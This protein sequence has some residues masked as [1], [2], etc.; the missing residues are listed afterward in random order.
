MLLE[1]WLP[2]R[3]QFL[4]ELLRLE[5][6]KKGMTRSSCGECKVGAIY[7]CK[8]CFGGEVTCKECI[9]QDHESHPLHSLEKWT[10]S[11]FEPTTLTSLGHVVQ[12]GHKLSTS[13]SNPSKPIDQTV[14]DLNG[15]HRIV[16]RF[17]HCSSSS[18]SHQ[19]QL[20][21]ARW[22]P[23][24]VFRPSTS[25]S[26]NL[27]DF[28]HKLQDQNKCNSYD[29]YHTIMQRSNNAK[30]EPEIFRYNE[31][32]LVFR[33]WSHLKLLK[34]G[35]AGHCCGGVDSMSDGSLAV[36]CPA[37]PQPGKNIVLDSK[38]P[39]HF[40]TT[41]L[42]IDGCFKTKLKDRGITDPDLGTGLAY[43]VNSADYA[44]HL[45]DPAGTVSEET[46]TSCGSDL[47]AVDQAY[48]RNPKGYSVTGVVAVSCRH[49]FVRP[50]GV[51]DLQKGERY[52]NVD[53]AFAS[54]VSHELEMGVPHLVVTYDIACQWGRH[55]RER[56]ARYKATKDV[57]LD[58]LQSFRVAVPKFHLIGHGNSC[59][60]DYN[61]AFMRGVGM[62]HGEGVETIWSHSTSLATWS[63]ENGPQ[64]R[65]AL[66]DTHWSGWNW[67][68][69]INLRRL[70]KKSLE[71]AW[72]LCKVQNGIAA[73]VTAALDPALIHSWTEMM[74]AYY[75][76]SSN[77]NPF[78]EVAPSVTLNDLKAELGRVD[79][80]VKKSGT[81]HAHET[82][83]SQFIM[84][85]L[86]IEEQQSTHPGL[87]R[88]LRSKRLDPNDNTTICDQ[89]RLLSQA[90]KSLTS[91]QRV[92]M[93]GASARLDEIDPTTIT[94][95]PKTVK[96][97]LPSQLP[98]AS[99]DTSCIGNLPRLELRFRLAQAYDALD[100]IR[101]LRGVY[102]VLLVKNQAHVSTSQGTMTRTKALFRNFAL[103]I[104][105]A[106]ARYRDA[107]TA[108]LRLDPE[109]KFSPW[110]NDLKDLC[111]E[112]IRGPSRETTDTSESRRELSWIWHTGSLQPDTGINDPQ[113]QGVMRVEWCKAVARA[114]RFQEE[115]ELLVE[116]MRRTLCFFDWNAGNWEKLGE[117]RVGE[118]TIDEEITVGMRAY[119]A[120]Q[121]A[122]YR[123][124]VH[125]FIADWYECLEL[126]SLGSHWLAKYP[127]PEAAR[128]RRRRLKSN[129]KMY[130]SSVF[131][132]SAGTEDI[133]ETEDALTDDP[134][135]D[136]DPD[137]VD[138]E[139]DVDVAL[140]DLDAPLW[141]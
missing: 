75:L 121:A 107:R 122:L 52:L 70:L 25:F 29:F 53:Y 110:K 111:R 9:L 24:T 38:H 102:Q 20:L 105:Q 99:R 77:P 59:H 108:L 58:S 49:S 84:R 92:Y 10:G 35:G 44:A 11:F 126:K 124:L 7:R 134:P 109:G 78:K 89:R 113:L 27:L 54:T 32:C 136:S 140:D 5:G 100:L 61:L 81:P 56:L 83:P 138:F 55:L 26:F 129:V 8:D 85:A 69:L 19:I 18:A 47:R 141:T 76:D 80:T 95:A 63:R 41:F 2:H 6:L 17:C 132:S 96:L 87:R 98:A 86:E 22:F 91:P 133:P 104:D 64:A 101:H 40:N 74:N 137:P 4:D 117:A 57:N 114:E 3:K 116:E 88:R 120:R 82:T 51:A 37:C 46:G 127:R 60:L 45:K 42:G 12:L 123:K 31:I 39:I 128:N 135:S 118:P 115:V 23:A 93:P 15:V 36:L 103:K 139:D 50:T 67:K 16:V 21:Q 30:L 79:A 34:R 73:A 130:H 72:K 71:R 66:L 90:I 125:V 33:L 48:T 13:C 94:D 28:F 43:M 106:A 62:T 68:K 112:D 97:W 1:E 65:Q 14:F 131:P 119:A